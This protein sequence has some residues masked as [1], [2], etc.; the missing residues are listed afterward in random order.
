[1]KRKIIKSATYVATYD[2]P[3]PYSDELDDAINWRLK[4]TPG[5][6]YGNSVPPDGFWI[7][8]VILLAKYEPD[9]YIQ[10][11]SQYDNIEN[12]VAGIFIDSLEL[13]KINED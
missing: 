3:K 1:M 7:F 10:I 6:Y 12:Y 9:L 13:F 2:M 5:F 4:E 8:P 11:I